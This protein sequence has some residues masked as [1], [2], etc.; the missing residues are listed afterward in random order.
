MSAP[1]VIVKERDLTAS[2]QA[3]GGVYNAI[4]L[5][6]KKGPVGVPVLVTNQTQFLQYFTPN[7]RVEVGYDLGYYSA[8]AI[9]ERANKLWVIRVANNAKYGGFNVYP[10]GSSKRISQLL[11]TEPEKPEL[12][13]SITQI[14]VGQK[15][16][17]VANIV[18][19]DGNFHNAGDLLG[20]IIEI[21]GATGSYQVMAVE[22]PDAKSSKVTLDRAVTSEKPTLTGNAKGAVPAVDGIDF[23]ISQVD[24]GDIENTKIWLYNFENG[25]FTDLNV[26][27]KVYLTDGNKYVEAVI[28]DK[29]DDDQ[30]IVVDATNFSDIVDNLVHGIN[31]YPAEEFD[32]NVTELDANVNVSGLKGDIAW[33]TGR[34][35]TLDMELSNGETYTNTYTIDS[36]DADNLVIT[37]NEQINY[38]GNDFE[39]PVDGITHFVPAK[40]EGFLDP[41]A[42]EFDPEA[43]IFITQADPGEWSKDIR[44]EIITDPEITKDPE[45]FILNVYKKDNLR[46]PLEKFTLSRI[47]GKK[48]GYGRNIYINDALKASNYIRGYNNPA[49]DEKILPQD[50]PLKHLGYMVA[51]D[52][53]DPVTE[54]NYIAATDILVNKQNYPVTII[55]DGGVTIPSFQK[56]LAEIAEIRK[57]C[58]AILSTPI[59]K[60][61]DNNYMVELLNYR[62]YDLN[63]DSSFAALYTSHLLIVDKFNDRDIYVSPDGYAAAAINYSA[64]NFEIWY[65]A[66]GQKRGKLYVK[67]VLRKFT[68][69]ELDALYDAG[70]NPIRFYVGRGISIWGQKTLKSIPSA[71]DRIN[72]RML[73]IVIENAI[74]V[75]LEDFLFDLND[76]LVGKM[77][78]VKIS[79]YLESIKARKGI[80]DY[81]VVSDQTNNS[82]WDYDHHIRNVDV[83]I[84]PTQ[85]LEWINFTTVLTPSGLSFSDAKAMK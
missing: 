49:V 15:D 77:I 11:E 3:F 38:P 61:L 81:L 84:K 48:D 30:Y 14:N 42:V 33:L 5:N 67:D 28:K 74:S 76:P 60:E 68:D 31:A 41:D 43:A 21:D 71:L 51:G 65:P 56:R 46:E 64:T 78:E 29:N 70:I 72:I 79:E 59:A 22:S 7:K 34:N 9:L 20:R 25:T 10:Q 82:T 4:F 75:F 6:A 24:S 55:V 85:S 66:A 63:L 12:K 47:P 69:G 36:V 50:L 2:P 1:K 83:Y 17:N 39:T 58:I 52:D 8:L 62:K 27:D 45:T 53:G 40:A 26:D 18:D 37:L 35:V 44:I 23:D 54:S 16:I 80:Q 73:L 57:D 32:A 19:V 13:F